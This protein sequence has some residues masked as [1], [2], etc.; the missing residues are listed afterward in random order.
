MLM[1]SRR[2]LW[3]CSILT[4]RKNGRH[5]SDSIDHGVRRAG[6]SGCRCCSR[7]LYSSIRGQSVRPRRESQ[8]HSTAAFR[9]GTCHGDGSGDFR[10]SQYKR[11]W[12]R[13]HQPA[14]RHCS[15]RQQ[16]PVYS[17]S[18][19]SQAAWVR[20][21]WAFRKTARASWRKT[22]AVRKPQCTLKTL[23][24]LRVPVFKQ[25]RMA[26]RLSGPQTTPTRLS[27]LPTTKAAPAQAAVLGQDAA[28][29]GL[30]NNGVLGTTTSDGWGVQGTSTN[31][32]FGGGGYCDERNRRRRL[33]KQW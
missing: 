16:A 25:S 9:H 24:H 7:W 11:C 29:N 1:C 32:A 6:R 12:L 18:S 28:N 3:L 31:G 26:T 20:A 17:V 15:V 13:H 30:F 27:V 33:F 21:S 14:V 19:I 23:A 22:L 5:F 4:R 10:G 8:S 2:A